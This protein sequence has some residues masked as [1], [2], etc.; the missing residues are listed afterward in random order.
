MTP[1]KWYNFEDASA[2]NK[3]LVKTDTNEPKDI[4]SISR[5]VETLRSE[6]R[7]Q[8]VYA[9]DSEKAGGILKIVEELVR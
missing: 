7:T 2:L 3:V 5:I 8:R 9:P 4:A 1:Y 6:Q